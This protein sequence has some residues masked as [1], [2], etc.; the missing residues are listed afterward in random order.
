[1]RVGEDD[2]RRCSRGVSTKNHGYCALVR[3]SFVSTMP[4]LC[5]RG[6][7]RTGVAILLMVKGFVS[8]SSASVG[9]AQAGDV[10]SLLLHSMTSLARNNYITA[11]SP[12][13]Q[14]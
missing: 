10:G 3:H 7:Y 6:T 4:K 13:P 8:G 2:L 1:M 12:D 5:I 11:Y 9:S 14:Y